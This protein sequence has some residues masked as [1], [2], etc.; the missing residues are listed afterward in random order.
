MKRILIIGGGFAGLSCMRELTRQ[1]NRLGLELTLVDKSENSNF[2][3][4]LPDCIGRG[5]NPRHLTYNLGEAGRK[6]KFKFIK[7]TITS[8][9]LERKEALSVSGNFNYDY[10]VI[11]CGSETNF[12]GNEQIK[13]YSYKLDDASD[14]KRLIWALDVRDYQNYFVTGGGYTGI[15]VATNL[16]VYLK[17]KKKEGRIIIVERAPSILGPLPQWMKDYVLKNLATLNIEVITEASI[18]EIEEERVILSTGESFK[19]SLLV[20]AAGV[21]CADF[22]QGLNVEKNQQGR[23]RADGYLRLN[24]SCFVTGDTAYFASGDN[25]LRMAVQFAIFEGRCAAENIIRSIEGKGLKEYRPH[26]LG[27]VIPMANN[28][29]CATVFGMNLKGLLPTLLHF[30]MCVFRSYGLKNKFGIIKD[31]M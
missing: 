18:G 19:D 21:R 13:K 31:L 22:I 2:L 6:L 20:W 24:D 14:A 9:S 15:E 28:N 4:M 3:P 25:F 26:D 5:I 12:Y 16:R 1:K 10:L 29:S 17:K 8:L 7:D 27:Y 30:I 11:A 23:I